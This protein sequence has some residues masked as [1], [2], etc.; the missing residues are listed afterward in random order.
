MG[1]SEVNV[2]VI[3]TNSQKCGEIYIRGIGMRVVVWKGQ[4]MVRERW[5]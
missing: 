1:G 4:E 5:N 2:L 3:R